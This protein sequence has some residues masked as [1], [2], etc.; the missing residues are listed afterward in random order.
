MILSPAPGSLPDGHRVY[1]IGDVHGCLD[2]LIALHGLIAADLAARPIAAPLL[3]HLG[4]YVDRGPDSAGV[5]ARLAV[6]APLPGI[7]VVN[8]MGNHENTML[9]AL[10]GDRAAATDWLYNGGDAAL[11]SWG[12]NSAT[13]TRED[14]REAIPTEHLAFLDGLALWHRVGGYVFVH[15]GIRPGLPIEAQAE[16]DLLWIRQV[17]LTSEADFGAIV[18]HGHTPSHAPVTRPNRIGIDTGAVYGGALTC[19]VLEGNQMGFLQT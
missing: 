17:F 13:T 11:A 9:E 6:G 3:V 14:W 18:V 16:T 2:Q 12:I 19:V 10:G 5:V 4:D 15:A 8:L 1:A 7:P